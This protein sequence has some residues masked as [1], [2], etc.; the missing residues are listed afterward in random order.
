MNG[1]AAPV[2]VVAP[3][4]DLLRV[5]AERTLDQLH[6][7]HDSLSNV[8]MVVPH[9]GVGRGVREAL[10]RAAAARGIGAL[11]G[12]RIVPYRSW[13]IRWSQRPLHHRA[14]RELYL[15]DLLRGFPQSFDHSD[16]WQVC[17]SLLPLL[18]ELDTQQ[19]QPAALADAAAGNP[20]IA[21]PLGQEA[22]VVAAV[23]SA[24]RDGGS[25]TSPLALADHANRAFERLNAGGRL[26]Q[27]VFVGCDELSVLECALL[28][29]ALENGQAMAL[30]QHHGQHPNPALAELLEAFAP[31][32]HG[33]TR[34]PGYGFLQH[35]LEGA[36]LEE[37][38]SAPGTGYRARWAFAPCIDDETQ[39]QF[40]A[41]D[42]VQTR[43]DAPEATAVVSENRKLL[44]RLRAVLESR[45]LPVEDESGWTLSTTAAATVV[46]RL[47]DSIEQDF[48]YL[49][50]LDL[51]KS[52][53]VAPLGMTGNDAQREAA[54]HR[55]ERRVVRRAQI[56]SGLERYREGITAHASGPHRRESAELQRALVDA[57]ETATRELTRV[58]VQHAV[59]GV[60]E[61]LTLLREA[62]E[63][64]G[65]GVRLARD[66]AG[67]QLL[68]LLSMLEQE[69]TAGVRLGWADTR[70]WLARV[71]E[72]ERFQ[73]ERS[74]AAVRL[75]N[76]RQAVLG[77]YDSVYLLGANENYFP[78][79]DAAVTAFFNDGVRAEL[80]LRT[81]SDA[82]ALTRHRFKLL[83]ANAQTVI[84]CFAR[85]SQG[86]PLR[87]TQWL[88]AL[89]C[90]HQQLYGEAL[91]VPEV[92]ADDTRSATTTPDLPPGWAEISARPAPAADARLIPDTLSASG[93]QRLIDC[94]YLFYVYDCL[95]LR[96]TDEI[97]EK[98]R[99]SEYGNRV[100]RCLQLFHQDPDTARWL[101]HDP[102]RAERRLF[103]ISA[104][105]FHPDLQD[106][107]EHRA[108]LHRWHRCIRGYIAWQARRARAY[109][110]TDTEVALTRSLGEGL[111]LKGTIDRIER[112]AEEGVALLD[113][114]TGRAPSRAAML[115]GEDVQLVTYA[116][117]LDGVARLEYL[118]LDSRRPQDSGLLDPVEIDEIGDA[119][120][121][122]LRRL[123]AGIRNG[124][125]LPA[126]QG[127]RCD[128]CDMQGVCRQPLWSRG[129]EV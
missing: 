83:L 90:S 21:A 100:H 102:Q 92:G 5:A 95:G 104:R 74:G 120:A 8:T 48:H 24:L 47:L 7:A 22:Q 50:F 66:P 39:I 121:D 115:N 15:Y 88:T 117:L 87:P 2:V 97:A 32:H 45:D 91:S 60:S 94:P 86:E 33:A 80:G 11:L 125:S 26:E 85:E 71:L 108:W 101:Q 4:V 67:A 124:A 9:A 10:S 16:L 112:D 128:Y 76:L 84:A 79:R 29:R 116:L 118:H 3:G 40:V 78:E 126:W 98:L 89:D 96:P 69:P 123:H 122:R 57:V 119:V 14:L 59:Q 109:R 77:C 38:V 12:P 25:T 13:L 55:F 106:N 6:H 58:H 62:L 103:E 105:V 35:C 113:Y 82:L 75:L 99:K 41:D 18:E 68:R 42:I 65:C 28:R 44:R 111:A 70:T 54:V 31:V 53:Y 46:Q 52:P 64:L 17:D 63:R 20:R 129:Q 110:V 36:P 127:P 107:F 61:F 72:Q 114:K 49:P 51:L 73:P 81:H 1:G 93:H 27:G 37:T 43:S 23:W 19:V 30:F 56:H 34:D